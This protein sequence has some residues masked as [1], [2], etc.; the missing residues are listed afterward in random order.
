MQWHHVA[1]VVARVDTDALHGYLHVSF[2][3]F[4]ETRVAG[5]P[6]DVELLRGWLES[7]AAAEHGSVS[8]W[9]RHRLCGSGAQTAVDGHASSG[10]PRCCHAFHEEAGL[11]IRFVRARRP[12]PRPEPHG[13]GCMGVPAEP[14]VNESNDSFWRIEERDCVVPSRVRPA[15]PPRI[16]RSTASR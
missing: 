11:S 9:E 8:T 4:A 2:L 16:R 5:S 7:R 13:L 10:A 12:A 15:S 1:G 14:A 3:M 6:S